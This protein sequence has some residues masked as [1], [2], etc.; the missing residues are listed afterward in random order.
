[1]NYG[2][3]VSDL[4]NKCE[5]FSRAYLEARFRLFGGPFDVEAP[6]E[7]AS[8]ETRDEAVQIKDELK[9]RFPKSMLKV[10]IVSR[11]LELVAF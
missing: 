11:E 9:K 5:N 2:Y 6:I 7:S 3:I 8:V 4:L 10:E 1:M